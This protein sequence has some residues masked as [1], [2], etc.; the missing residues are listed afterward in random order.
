MHSG[1]KATSGM[2]RAGTMRDLAKLLFLQ[3]SS[4]FSEAWLLLSIA[5]AVTHGCDRQ[6][7]STHRHARMQ[8]LTS[9]Q[10]FAHRYALSIFMLSLSVSSVAIFVGSPGLR[11]L[12]FQKEPPVIRTL[13]SIHHDR[14]FSPPCH[15]FNA[16][17]VIPARACGRR[18]CAQ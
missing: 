4:L 11:P 16:I 2:K 18:S 17:L 7:S 3:H 6:C 8:P 9:T 14:Y 10:I 13:P 12:Q 15:S 1:I 5:V